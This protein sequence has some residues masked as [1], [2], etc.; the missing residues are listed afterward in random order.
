MQTIMSLF[1]IPKDKCTL[2]T[3]NDCTLLSVWSLVGIPVCCGLVWKKG[4]VWHGKTWRGKVLPAAR[5]NFFP[6]TRTK[7]FWREFS[8]KHEP[9]FAD[10]RFE[11]AIGCP[12]ARKDKRA[13]KLMLSRGRKGGYV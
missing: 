4:C 6:R 8:A 5:E 9:H 11:N 12:Q 7:K 3:F 2:L 1:R 13:A 10:F